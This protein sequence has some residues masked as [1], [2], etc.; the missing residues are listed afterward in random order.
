[1][2]PLAYVVPDYLQ[3]FLARLKQ[4]RASTSEPIEVSDVLLLLRLDFKL[5]YRDPSP[6]LARK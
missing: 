4:S 1:M 5:P 6:T 3:T 2:I